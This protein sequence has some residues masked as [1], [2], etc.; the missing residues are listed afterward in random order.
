MIKFEHFA[1]DGSGVWTVDGSVMDQWER[2]G[3]VIFK[4]EHSVIVNLPGSGGWPSEQL[5]F[6]NVAAL[7]SVPVTERPSYSNGY[8]PEY[9]GI[10]NGDY[11]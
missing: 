3:W 11:V 1:A 4:S 7:T 8:P 2:N 5:V 6:T 9:Y 10:R